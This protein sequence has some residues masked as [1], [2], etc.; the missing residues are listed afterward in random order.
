MRFQTSRRGH[1][2]EG[3]LPLRRLIAR[4]FR[5]A[6]ALFRPGRLLK[7]GVFMKKRLLCALICLLALS[8]PLSACGTAEDDEP[9]AARARNGVVRV[10]SVLPNLNTG[11][12]EVSTGTAFGVGR[13]GEPTDVFVTNTHVVQNSYVDSSGRVVDAPAESVY[14][15][16]GDI[17]WSSSLDPDLSLLIP[18][19]VLYASSGDGPD[20][21]VIRAEEAPEGRVALPLLSASDEAVVGEDVYAL[22]YPGSSDLT[23]GGAYT[24]TLLADAEDVTVTRGVISRLTDSA[25]FNARLIQHD[26]QINHGNSGGPLIN[27]DGAVVGIN[28]YLLGGDVST[29]DESAYYSVSIA[30]ARDKLDELGLHYDV[31]V[32]SGGGGPVWII[33]LAAAVV[34]ALALTLFLALRSRRRTA[35]AHAAHAAGPARQG[36][37][38][39]GGGAEPP[40]YRPPDALAYQPPETADYPGDW[41]ARGPARPAYGYAPAREVPPQGVPAQ[42]A[43]ILRGVSG[44]FAG[45]SFA[46][47]GRLSIGRGAEGND[48]AY[49]AD[50][51]GISRRHCMLLVNSGRL[52]VRDLGSSYGTFLSGGRRLEPMKFAPLAPGSTISLGSINE[53]FIIEESGGV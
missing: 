24:Q 40:A 48:V 11:E 32:P 27:P 7:R 20:Y 22:G 31:Y 42:K 18:C 17:S 37:S 47:N 3:G 8:L 16:E 23:E 50:T 36:P 53:S 6:P 41:G 45:R 25:A 19:T 5:P 38:A 35:G 44:V 51:R 9:V 26:A 39:F 13:A 10:L 46:V 43:F 14:I 52:Y 30:Y 28:T 15:I 33:A 4:L 1:K 29:G 12:L 21:A 2:L 49:P 34:L